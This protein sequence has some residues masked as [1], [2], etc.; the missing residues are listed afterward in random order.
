MSWFLRV[1]DGDHFRDVAVLAEGDSVI[2]GRAQTADIA[3]PHDGEMSSRHASL[4]IRDDQCL[5]A[6]LQSTNGS[7][8]NG[9]PALEGALVPGAMLQCGLTILSVESGQNPTGS[10]PPVAAATGSAPPESATAT[11]PSQAPPQQQTSAV[12]PED[13]LLTKG[14]VAKS[15]NEIIE[16]FELKDQFAF[17][18][19]EGETPQQ[20][21]QR[22]HTSG[23]PS[24][25]LTFLA[26]ALPKRLG[27]WWAINC[28]RSEEGLVGPDD[29]SIVEA[30]I[31]WIAEPS[32]IT[33]RAAMTLAEANGIETASAWAAV[34]AFWSH[35]SMGPKDQPEVPA[36]DTLAGKA[37][38]GA[39]ILASVAQSPE[40]AAKRRT[41]F[42]ELAMDVATEEIP[43]P[44]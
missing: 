34:T 11:A 23:E 15:A 10:A 39:V 16:R 27:V 4:T 31:D 25:C 36:G 8:L 14:F 33:R 1:Q 19:D 42:L 38:S 5:F 44:D 40:N 30:V 21:S 2:V 6:D 12:L 35:G 20:F 18:S 26:Y 22:L 43:L 28:L 3:F 7:F 17:V 37:L 24:D 13:L 32:D 29:Q 9:E 41:E